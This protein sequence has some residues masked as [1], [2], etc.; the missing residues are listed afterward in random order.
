M[1]NMVPAGLL[2]VRPKG[3]QADVFLDFVIPGYR[4]FRAGKFLFEE[5]AD[6]FQ[7]QGIKRLVSEPGN[8]RHESYLRRMG[9]QL[10]NGNYYRAVQ[11]K[12][13]VVTMK[14]MLLICAANP[15]EPS[16]LRGPA[17]A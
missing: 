6:Y 12:N 15:W 13:G 14:R 10:E 5:S 2:I 4:D 17:T 7:S 16:S 8:P 3:D 9:F 1:R 11:P